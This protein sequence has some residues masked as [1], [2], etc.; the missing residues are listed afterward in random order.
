MIDFMYDHLFGPLNIR[1]DQIVFFDGKVDLLEESA[2]IDGYLK[3]TGAI[4]F[5]LL[6]MGMN[7]HLGL[8]EPGTAFD[9]HSHAAELDS[10][11][12]ATAK[13]YFKGPSNLLRGITIGMR[14]IADAKR[15]VLL[16]TGL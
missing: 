7:G 12:A 11:T 14:D 6:G 1:E 3:K 15:V 4:D 13:K 5:L 9:L 8:N 10:V 16:A 2:R